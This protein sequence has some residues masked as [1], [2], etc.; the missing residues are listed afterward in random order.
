LIDVFLKQSHSI[1]ADPGE[2]GVELKP[3]PGEV[4]I[5]IEIREIE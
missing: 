3:F 5:F 2:R 1:V 4:A